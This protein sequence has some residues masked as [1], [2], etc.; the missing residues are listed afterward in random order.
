MS[1]SIHRPVGYSLDH[2]SARPTDLISLKPCSGTQVPYDARISAA[3]WARMAPSTFRF[4]KC[5]ALG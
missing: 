4:V 3:L 1:Q 2:L 5:T